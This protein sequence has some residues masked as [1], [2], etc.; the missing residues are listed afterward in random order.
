[1][2]AYYVQYPGELFPIYGAN[3]VEEAKQYIPPEDYDHIA[4]SIDDVYMNVATG[5]V[6]FESGWDDLSEVIPV[7]WNTDSES[8]EDIES[9]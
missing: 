5:S 8:W 2:N 7:Y 6:D 3:S 9:I 4:V 1:M